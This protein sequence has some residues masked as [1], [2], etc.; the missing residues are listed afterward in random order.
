MDAT[1][2]T[3]VSDN[4]YLQTNRNIIQSETD[5]LQAKLF[6]RVAHVLA[7]KGVNVDGQGSIALDID[8]YGKIVVVG[9]G[10]KNK[11]EIKNALEGNSEIISILKQYHVEGNNPK[12]T[13]QRQDSVGIS[14]Q[15]ASAYEQSVS[16]NG[17]DSVQVLNG[18][19]NPIKHSGVLEKFNNSHI[20]KFKAMMNML[21][22]PEGIPD[23]LFNGGRGDGHQS[24]IYDIIEVFSTKVSKLQLEVSN[25]VESLLLDHDIVL[26]EDEELS[27][28]VDD[29]GDIVVEPAGDTGSEKARSRKI[30][31]ALNSDSEVKKELA[32]SLLEID[33]NEQAGSLIRKMKISAQDF[34]DV[35][36]ESDNFIAELAEF[37]YGQPLEILQDRGE[38][39]INDEATFKA[40]KSLK[41]EECGDDS[42][43]RNSTQK[44][45]TYKFANGKMINSDI[46]DIVEDHWKPF[47]DS[48]NYFLT[49]EKVN[50]DPNNV[51]P[52][53]LGDVSTI[54]LKNF[55][56]EVDVDGRVEL[57]D[58]KDKLG[59]DLDSSQKEIL[60]DKYLGCGVDKGRSPELHSIVEKTLE[61][62][63]YE[64]NDTDE[65]EHK[66]RITGDVK[67][68]SIVY[69]VISPAA[70]EAATDELEESMLAINTELNENLRSKGVITPV[71]IKVSEDGR[72][73]ADTSQLSNGEKVIIDT[74][75]DNINNEVDHQNRSMYENAE[76]EKKEDIDEKSKKELEAEKE[77]KMREL[78]G[79]KEDTKNIELDKVRKGLARIR[80]IGYEK[81]AKNSEEIAAKLESKVTQSIGGEDENSI[82]ISDKLE[83]AGKCVRELPSSLKGLEKVIDIAK[84][85]KGILDKFHDRDNLFAAIA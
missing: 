50:T 47:K 22:V 4:S 10:I 9:R 46:D 42:A 58:A 57:I 75:L 19:G 34:I 23:L 32:D 84:G 38:R 77:D 79:R 8:E 56:V 81:E 64:H 54:N 14:S 15:A 36:L 40:I 48:I 76:E 3:G 12:N 71:E 35:L 63:E 26:G 61:K 30:E 33:F 59:D 24:P 73:E 51:V 13:Y 16:R 1:V 67:T 78:E 85:L 45:S 44:N 20:D 29:K 66:I 74:V 60:F 55:E 25:F 43:T 41:I 83:K 68:C 72:L 70:D 6:D 7:E 31:D 21:D 18:N 5:S 82:S 27:L 49:K 53:E 2:C 37:K 80:D 69:E 62:H 52:K 28:Y 11:D 39:I 65:Y 17:S